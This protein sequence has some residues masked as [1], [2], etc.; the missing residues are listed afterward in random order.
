MMSIDRIS[1]HGRYAGHDPRKEKTPGYPDRQ[2]HS[3]GE[4]HQP[5]GKRPDRE[6]GG[7]AA[8]EDNKHVDVSV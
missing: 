4:A 6:E 5:H 8:I 1:A 7:D 3:K 2:P